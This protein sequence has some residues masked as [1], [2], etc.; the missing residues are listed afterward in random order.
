MVRGEC[1]AAIAAP[2]R[3][4]IDLQADGSALYTVQALWSQARERLDVLTVIY[5]NRA[6][7]ILE[8]ELRGVGAPDPGPNAQRMLRL[9][10]PAVDW[11]SVAR[12]FG[13]EAVRVDTIAG[14]VD[15]LRAGLG[16][17]GPFLIEAVI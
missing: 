13:V 3:R 6:Y 10:D 4:V 9:D 17:S 2:G 8:G 16:R 11:V 15:A 1:I 12:G 14:F 5:A 7:K